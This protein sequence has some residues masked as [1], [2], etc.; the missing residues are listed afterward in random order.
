MVYKSVDNG[1]LWSIWL[2]NLWSG[3]LWRV[4]TYEK[5]YRLCMWELDTHLPTGH[6]DLSNPRDEI[7]SLL[8]DFSWLVVQSPKNGTTDLW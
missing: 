6:H 4:V 2:L 1:K 5:W 8:S 7:S 3:H